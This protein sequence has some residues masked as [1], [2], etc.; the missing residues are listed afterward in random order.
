MNLLFGRK[1]FS[2]PRVVCLLITALLLYL[3]FRRIDFNGLVAALKHLQPAWF[4]CAFGMYGLA[5]ILGGLRWNL[6]LRV[7]DTAMHPGAS[8]RLFLIGHFFFVALFGAAGGDAAKSAVY[9][10]WYG[11]DMAKVIASAPLDRALGIGG[12]LLLMGVLLG[13]AGATDGFDAM[14]HVSFDWP[15]TWVLVAC[16]IGAAVLLVVILW[17]PAGDSSWARAAR[18]FRSGGAR[19][20]LTPGIAVP[21][22][23]YGFGAQLALSAVLAFNLQAVTQTP[24]DWGQLAWTFPV[25]TLFSCLPF[26]VAG[27]GVREI[28]ALAFLTPYGATPGE[29][30]AAS[31]LTFFHKVAWAV[32]GAFALWMEQARRARYQPTPLPQ[33]I[34][35]VMPVWNEADSLRDTILRAK[36]NPEIT[37]VI[38]VD[39]GSSDGSPEIARE[40]GCKVLASPRGRGLQMRTGAEAAQND[41][42]LFLHADTWLPPSA[43]HAALNCL[44]DP[45]VVAGGFWKVFR[46][47]PWLLLGSRYRCAVRLFV[48]RRIAGDQC[49]FVRRA[50][51]QRLGGFPEIPL[52]EEFEL[53]RRLRKVGR[54]A[55]AE[56]TVSTSARR[57]RKLGVLRT[58]WRMWWVT[59]LWRLGVSPA[60]LRAIY[61]KP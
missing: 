5:M 33:T 2:W 53:C 30:V 38:V 6:A 40:L 14:R 51:L 56:A 58:Y 11:F 34:S 36:A 12:P 15:G 52:M 43:A 39:G 47:T 60:K 21:G 31:L 44:R 59:T 13:I 55:L 54:L 37:E 26:T 4:V 19:M 20:A 41:V 28:A 25:I 9:A 18:A 3:I 29:C 61:E 23:V 8:C 57:F 24:L 48:G 10:R 17:R 49:L 46:N 50:V 1:W 22:L 42:I 16:A 7:T 45:V 32:L 35:V 27:A